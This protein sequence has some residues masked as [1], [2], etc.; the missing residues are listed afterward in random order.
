MNVHLTPELEQ[1]V[2]RKVKTGRYNS[3]SEVLREALRLMEERDHLLKFRK[4]ELSKQIAAGLDALRRGEGVDGEEFFA[5][6]ESREA[7]LRQREPANPAGPAKETARR[8][9][10]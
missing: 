7:I 4:E 10:A 2:Q 3:A 9:T 8:K 5:Q 1:F 6:L